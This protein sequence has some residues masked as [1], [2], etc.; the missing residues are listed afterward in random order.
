[1]NTVIRAENIVT[2]FG[3]NLVHDGI[4][5][6]VERGEIYGLLGGSG[7][8]KSTLMKEMIMLL[9]PDSGALH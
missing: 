9:R 2:R 6:T 8:G 7:S 5:L 4:S 1:M 3:R